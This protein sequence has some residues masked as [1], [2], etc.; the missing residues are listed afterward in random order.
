MYTISLPQQKNEEIPNPPSNSNCLTHLPPMFKIYVSTVVT[1]SQ[2]EEICDMSQSFHCLLCIVSHR[3]HYEWPYTLTCICLHN[4]LYTSN[5]WDQICEFLP[6]LTDHSNY[7]LSNQ[8]TATRLSK[9][10]EAHMGQKK[11]PDNVCTTDD[12]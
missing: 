1:H 11:Q 12:T 10:D 8:I 6:A 9:Q 7:R 2:G 4:S 3:I 5:W